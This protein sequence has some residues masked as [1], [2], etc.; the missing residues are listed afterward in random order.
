MDQ[1]VEDLIYD[2]G[3]H[4]GEDTAYYLAKGYRV[5]AFE[6]H[7]EL[8]RH[9]ELRFTEALSEARLEIV[10]G[11]IADVPGDNV[12]FFIH[13]TVSEWGTVDQAWVARND[14][15]IGGS[16]P[17]TVPK[18]NV[19]AVLERT[20]MP[21]YMKVDIE[22]ADG[23]CFD[24]IRRFTSRPRYV[25]LESSKTRNGFERELTMLRRLG[26]DEFA[27]IQQA[28]IGG[29]TIETHTR[30]GRS[31]TYQFEPAA[32]GGFG[33]DI[34]G[35]TDQNGAIRAYRIPRAMYALFGDQGPIRRTRLGNRAL[36]RLSAY[37][38]VPLPGWHDTHAR[39]RIQGL[40]T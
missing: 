10:R 22:G 20:G 16:A 33:I 29:S 31:L 38:P 37:S 1:L 34:T 11:A 35:W 9:A 36:S 5:V 32:S 19:A 15:L 7:P 40:A 24:A 3:M 39:H 14:R 28:T 18:V 30:S 6:A 27:L 12:T 2:V 8:V 25:S 23:I 13:S 21:F 26:Y 17:V 4:R